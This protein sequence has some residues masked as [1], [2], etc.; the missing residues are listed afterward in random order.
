MGSEGLFVLGQY[1]IVFTPRKYWGLSL[2]RIL[3]LSGRSRRSV[4]GTQNVNIIDKGIIHEFE[5]N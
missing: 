2:T 3:K 5:V 1:F 4:Y